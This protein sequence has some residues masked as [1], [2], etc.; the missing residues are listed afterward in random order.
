MFTL[1]VNVLAV[2]NFVSNLALPVSFIKAVHSI[3]WGVL[4][5]FCNFS[6]KGDLA[7]NP[8]SVLSQVAKKPVAKKPV[9]KKPVA[10]KPVR[11]D[12]VRDPFVSRIHCRRRMGFA[13]CRKSARACR[14]V[15]KRSTTKVKSRSHSVSI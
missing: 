1:A 15:W 8:L 7:R 9:A 10:K 4:R 3:F 2:V 11:P 6:V 14:R 5:F 12:R 13:H